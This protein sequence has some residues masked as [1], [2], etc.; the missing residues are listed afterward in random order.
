MKTLLK[1]YN[2]RELEGID[3]FYLGDDF[4]VEFDPKLFFL[5]R[6]E[7][8]P[9]EDDLACTHDRM[10]ELADRMARTEPW[11]IA[12]FIG[13]WTVFQEE[14]SERLPL[15]PVYSNFYYDFYTAGLKNYSI[16]PKVTWGEALTGGSL[17]T[18][19]Q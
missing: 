15:I 17:S 11:D 6:E 2:D 19:Q 16:L 7:E 12:G 10:Y 4:N 5:H 18:P 1:A 13:K 14:L 9:E 3:M 8:A